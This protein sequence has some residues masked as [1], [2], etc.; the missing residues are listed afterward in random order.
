MQEAFEPMQEAIQPKPLNIQAGIS[1]KF[2]VLPTSF[3][4]EKCFYWYLIL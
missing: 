4:M 2:I 1:D 3:E